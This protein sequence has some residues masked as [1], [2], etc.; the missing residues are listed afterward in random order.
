M[1]VKRSGSRLVENSAGRGRKSAGA[2]NWRKC[3]GGASATLLLCNSQEVTLC[4]PDPDLGGSHEPQGGPGALTLPVT[5]QHVA[6]ALLEDNADWPGQPVTPHPRPRP[7]A[8]VVLPRCTAME[9][10]SLEAS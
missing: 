7:S 10:E 2:V 4:L 6:I 8:R 9:V 3:H 1:A 5:G